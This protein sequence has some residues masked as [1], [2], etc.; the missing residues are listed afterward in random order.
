MK[1]EKKNIKDLEKLL[2]EQNISVSKAH[3]IIFDT[4]NKKESLRTILK[5]WRFCLYARFRVKD[6]LV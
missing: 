5:N 1:S 4:V 2:K 3:K 6:F